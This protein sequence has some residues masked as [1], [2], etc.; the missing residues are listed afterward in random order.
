MR[1]HPRRS[2]PSPDSGQ[3]V[4]SRPLTVDSSTFCGTASENLTLWAK[5]LSRADT[6]GTGRSKQR[7]RGTNIMRD[8]SQSHEV[9]RK[10][11][12]QDG[13]PIQGHQAVSQVLLA[14]TWLASPRHPGS[15][16]VGPVVPRPQRCRSNF[17]P[18][19]RPQGSSAGKTNPRALYAPWRLEVEAGASKI[20]TKNKCILAKMKYF[21]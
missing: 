7:A 15:N 17:G 21:E 16:F 12:R 5:A 2:G 8:D 11:S 3:S 19:W 9:M 6:T 18:E 1:R 4:A 14:L 20:T 10:R 13:H